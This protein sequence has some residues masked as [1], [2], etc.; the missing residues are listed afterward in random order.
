MNLE[1]FMIGKVMIDCHSYDQQGKMIDG[2]LSKDRI[3]TDQFVTLCDQS[4]GHLDQSRWA[5][6]LIFRLH[7]KFLIV[8]AIFQG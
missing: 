4:D 5:R 8:R 6:R 7:F 1:G 3:P 2:Q